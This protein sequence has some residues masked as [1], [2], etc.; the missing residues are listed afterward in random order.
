MTKFEQ[1]AEQAQNSIDYFYLSKDKKQWLNNVY[2]LTD[3]AQ[4]ETFHYWWM[5]HL[6]DV[7]IDAYLRTKNE[8]YLRLA[9]ETYRY[10]KERNNGTLLHEYYDDMLWNALAA[11]RLYQQTNKQMYLADAREVCL[12]IFDTAWNDQMDGGFAW[13]R[14][15]LD[16][17]NTPVNGPIMILALRL[18]QIEENPIYLEMSKKTLAWMKKTLVQE[19]SKFV[20]DGVNRNGDGK[21]DYQ[22]KFTYNQGVYIG[23]LIEFYHV[24][25]DTRYLE[26]ALQCAQTSIDVLVEK[27]VFNDEGDGGDIGLF[28]GIEYRYLQLLYKE[29]HAEFIRSFIESSCQI[30]AEHGKRGEYLLAYRDWL[31]NKPESVC[32]SDHL[33]GVMALESAASL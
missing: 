12:D 6:I 15:Q 20:E 29:T 3:Q 31:E 17:K 10:N 14:T 25:K 7:R 5:A 9:A 22:W 18:Y 26:E 11:L 21:I 19:D 16:Y 30:L 33:S 27:G 8:E 32:L 4:N 13:K 23:A 2:P 1:L 24:T 28:K